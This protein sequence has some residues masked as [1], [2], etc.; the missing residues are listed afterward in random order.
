M[1]QLTKDLAPGLPASKNERLS[2]CTGME[3]NYASLQ[4]ARVELT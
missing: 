1:G 4:H 2:N 3:P